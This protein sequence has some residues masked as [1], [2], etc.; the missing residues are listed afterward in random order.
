MKDINLE[1]VYF[2]Q[3]CS[4]NHKWR[5]FSAS[6]FLGVGLSSK[7]LEGITFRIQESHKLSHLTLLPVVDAK[8]TKSHE[9][10]EEKWPVKI[11]NY[12]KIMCRHQATI[13]TMCP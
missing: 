9:R 8:Q 5:R 7:I 13:S 6:P 1:N 4:F 10:V 2:F 3:S 12:L 11:F